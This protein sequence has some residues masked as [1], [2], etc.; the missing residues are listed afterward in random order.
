[1]RIPAEQAARYGYLPPSPAGYWSP[2]GKGRNRSDSPE[3][4]AAAT[5]DD[6]GIGI[7]EV[8]G[9]PLLKGG[10]LAEAVRRLSP[11]SPP[12]DARVPDNGDAS[13]GD[14]LKPASPALRIESEAMHLTAKDPRL[15]A[16]L[17][18]WRRCMTRRGIDER[19]G[20]G[21]GANEFGGDESGDT[22][23]AG[24]RPSEEEIRVAKADSACNRQANVQEVWVSVASEHQRKLIG[25]DRARLEAVREW[26]NRYAANAEKVV[27]EHE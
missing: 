20:I 4:A 11:G 12:E 26:W 13:P 8:N 14:A 23:G 19:F 27:V 25:A 1:M 6:M 5:G 2:Q 22:H 24:G 10:C 3:E 16:A 18:E 17:S 7:K 21:A 9:K 15:T